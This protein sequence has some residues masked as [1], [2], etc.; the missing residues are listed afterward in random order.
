MPTLSQNQKSYLLI[1]LQ[2]I[3]SSNHSQ[4][5]TLDLLEMHGVQDMF[6]FVT[7]IFYHLLYQKNPW[8]F[9][10]ALNVYEKCG[11]QSLCNVFF[12]VSHKP[13]IVPVGWKFGIMF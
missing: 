3:S 13:L 8:I 2:K 6:L 4:H 7:S 9:C 11:F 10:I 1:F 12:V 5:I